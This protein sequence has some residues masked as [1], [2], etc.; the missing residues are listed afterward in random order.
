MKK[1]R[2]GFCDFWDDF[3]LTDNFFTQR[4]SRFYDL[5]LSS[6][7][8]VLIYSL[9]AQK[10]RE[11]SCKKIAYIG[12]NVRP[13]FRDCD[14][15]ISF[16]HL[17]NPRH[18]RWPIYNLYHHMAEFPVFTDHREKFCAVVIT[19]PEGRFRNEFLDRLSQV[20]PVDSGGKFR[21]NI[22]APV[23]DKNAFL[24]QYR[25]SF[26]FENSSHPGYTTEKVVQSKLAGT[27]PIYW[28]D[29]RVA[30]DFNTKSFI[31]VHDF[32]GIDA[33][34][35]HILAVDAD[36]ARYEEI[37]RQPLLKDGRTTPFCDR[38][39]FDRWIIRAVEA[40]KWCHRDPW[41]AWERR[42]HHQLQTILYR[43]Q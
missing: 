34:I 11:Y 23:V 37:R 35:D 20:R 17:N 25:F 4:L 19:N 15:A 42:F 36:P 8:D 39:V 6:D 1:L 12:E 9:F 26:A 40:P 32:P 38:N 28:G 43:G 22:G 27:I 30:D 2:L 31:N 41:S 24:Q 13:D 33:C 21:N 5:E 7:P 18:L 29:P 16:D 10:H 14:Y 3:P